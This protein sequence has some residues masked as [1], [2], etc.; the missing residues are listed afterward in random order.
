MASGASISRQKNNMAY[1]DLCSIQIE[2]GKQTC[3]LCLK[4]PIR[5]V[6]N[7]YGN[8]DDK[9][10]QALMDM[11]HDCR[12]PEPCRMCVQIMDATHEELLKLKEKYDIQ[13]N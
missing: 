3:D 4:N 13:D 8:E 9:I 2:E 12:K 10:R 7:H 11:D 6:V 5:S 1:C